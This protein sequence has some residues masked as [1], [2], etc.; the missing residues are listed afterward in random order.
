MIKDH[1][2]CLLAQC[3]WNSWKVP[4]LLTKVIF[5]MPLSDRSGPFTWIK[6]SIFYFPRPVDHNTVE[7]I[8]DPS[9]TLVK[10]GSNLN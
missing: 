3:M 6:E 4:Y 7:M 5:N 10:F 9:W 2:I 8:P 1:S